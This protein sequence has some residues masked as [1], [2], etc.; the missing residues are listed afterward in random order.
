M[1]ITIYTIKMLICI[2]YLLYYIHHIVIILICY[3]T[4]ILT[5]IIYLYVCVFSAEECVTLTNSMTSMFII[6]K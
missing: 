5:I 4:S 2:I 6:Q 3:N 1:Y